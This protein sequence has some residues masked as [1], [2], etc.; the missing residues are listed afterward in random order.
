[1]S[2]PLQSYHLAWLSV[3][4]SRTT[5]WLTRMMAEGF[6]VHHVDG[7]HSNDEPSN[8]ILIEGDDH[9]RLHGM[10][11]QASARSGHRTRAK[12]SKMAAEEVG[13]VAIAMLR[14]GKSLTQIIRHTGWSRS[15]VIKHMKNRIEP[16]I[17]KL[18]TVEYV[19]S[20]FSGMA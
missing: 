14:D 4:P 20:V 2:K 1:M 7:D 6:H 16:T 5:D 15:S 3:H 8:L 17:E 11:V 13:T 9:L 19:S 18:R 12:K 10:D